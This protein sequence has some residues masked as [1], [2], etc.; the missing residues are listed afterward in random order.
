MKRIALAVATIVTSLSLAGMTTF[1]AWTD[2]VTVTNNVVQ[3]GS[4]DL[5]VSNNNGVTWNTSTTASSMVISGLVPGAATTDAYSYSLWN[6]SSAGADFS[7]TGQITA[8][9]IA[10]TAGVDK[11]QLMLTVYRTDTNAD[12]SVEMSLAAW[13]AAPQAL[14]TSLVQGATRNY[15]IRARLASTALNEWQGQTVTFTLSVIGSTP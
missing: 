8:S 13:E 3:T 14:T 4:V 6:N 10:P 1:A 9:A 11:T 2:T 12:E 15:G 5:Q 7:L